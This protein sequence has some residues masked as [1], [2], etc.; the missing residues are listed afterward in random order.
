MKK[1]S[2]ELS[3]V[4]PVGSQPSVPASTSS[5]K[6]K[7]AQALNPASQTAEISNLVELE[8]LTRKLY[9]QLDRSWQTSPTFEH[10]L[11]YR[12]SVSADGAIAGYEPLNQPARDYVGEIPLPS[13]LGAE[14]AGTSNRP[15]MPI[16]RFTVV[17]S[18][19]GILEVSR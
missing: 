12:V 1:P 19:S 14:E 5:S 8:V 18:P 15:E 6:E 4:A 7:A 16:A 13:L 10:N 11:V 3:E 9:D 17:F 2:G